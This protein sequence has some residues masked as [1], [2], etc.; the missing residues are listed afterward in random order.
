MIE[1]LVLA[2][3]ASSR[4]NGMD[5]LLMDARGEPLLRRASKGALGSKADMVHVL[6]PPRSPRR[7]VLDGLPVNILEVDNSAHGMSASIRVGMASL[8]QGCTAVIIALADMPD[9]RACHFDA[10]IVAHSPKRQI[11]RAQASDGT[12]GNPVLFG[13]R[14]FPELAALT[15]DKGARGLIISSPEDLHMVP[16]AGQGAVCDLNTP[17]AWAMWE[18]E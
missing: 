12:P 16:T 3:G 1:V 4:M 18:K 13:K 15:G 14:F 5:K 11:C 8:S 6:I 10:L 9:V 2:A 7:D 17:A